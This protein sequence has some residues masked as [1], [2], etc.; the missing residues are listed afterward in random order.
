MTQQLVIAE[1]ISSSNIT[2][3]GLREQF[4]DS[5]E[6]SYSI[7]PNTESLLTATV[8]ET[9]EYKTVIEVVERD[10]GMQLEVHRY[11]SDAVSTDHMLSEI[12]D[13]YQTVREAL[14]S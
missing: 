12:Q 3:L 2:S 4:E 6:P 14:V 8:E 5:Y 1:L 11:V 7:E 13:V 9:D 10:A